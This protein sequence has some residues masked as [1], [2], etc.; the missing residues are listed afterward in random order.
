MEYIF[1][2]EGD[3]KKAA[4]LYEETL[5]INRGSGEAKISVAILKNR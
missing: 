4:A 2:R 5:K 3:L 1:E